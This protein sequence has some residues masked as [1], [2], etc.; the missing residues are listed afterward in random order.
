MIPELVQECFGTTRNAEWRPSHLTYIVL[1]DWLSLSVLSDCKEYFRHHGHLIS[2][3][4]DLR[5]VV[6]NMDYDSWL[7][8]KEFTV[9]YPRASG[10]LESTGDEVRRP[11]LLF[12]VTFVTNLAAGGI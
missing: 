10:S 6:G 8:F 11:I 9:T 5:D 12:V 1:R 3:F 4:N 7:D 2:C